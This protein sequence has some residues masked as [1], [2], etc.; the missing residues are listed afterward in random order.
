MISAEPVRNIGTTNLEGNNYRERVL[1]ET[2]H[3]R[4]EISKGEGGFFVNSGILQQC[5]RQ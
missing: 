3:G 2:D 1:F 5:L 4:A